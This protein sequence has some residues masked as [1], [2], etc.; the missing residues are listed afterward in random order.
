MGGG[1][2]TASA[3]EGLAQGY[4]ASAQGGANAAGYFPSAA[5][6]MSHRPLL[7][8]ETED[9]EAAGAQADRGS[10]GDSASS[11]LTTTLAELEAGAK[12]GETNSEK[13]PQAQLTGSSDADGANGEEAGT[14]STSSGTHT[15]TQ[16]DTPSVGS[17]LS[18][19]GTDKPTTSDDAPPQSQEQLPDASEN[20]AGP[21]EEPEAND[22]TGSAD[23]A[24]ETAGGTKDAEKD[25]AAHDE[26]AAEATVNKIADSA[27]RD[28]A[29]QAT[30]A[31]TQSNASAAP[32]DSTVQK[33]TDASKPT[34][35]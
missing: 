4:S 26:N 11:S 1:V 10:A 8:M 34:M 29:G 28:T 14:A 27:S 12:N 5:Q 2:C 21:Q 20:G 31:S 3:I 19:A 30:N 23:A 9:V 15:H 35:T 16:D 18:S 33:K 6:P 24:T 22:S 7:E 32:S 17:A 13:R 25:I